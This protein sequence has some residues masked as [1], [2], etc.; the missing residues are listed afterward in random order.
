MPEFVQHGN[1]VGV[2]AADPETVRRGIPR[3][4]AGG[5]LRVSKSRSALRTISLSMRDP[6]EPVQRFFR[7]QFEDKWR[8]WSS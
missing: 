1:G 7:A 3:R 4:K 5:R 8:Q 6:E 2:D